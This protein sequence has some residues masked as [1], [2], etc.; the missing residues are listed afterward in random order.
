MSVIQAQ[1]SAKE[2]RYVRCDDEGRLTTNLEATIDDVLMKGE[3]A[4]GVKTPV[5]VQT[6]GKLESMCFGKTGAGVDKE[7]LV[8]SDGSFVVGGGSVKVG[9]TVGDGSGTG[10]FLKTASDGSVHVVVENS[11]N[12]LIKG[13][14]DGTTTQKDA[15]T[16]SNGD[17]RSALIGNTSKDGTGT[18]YY[19]LVDADGKLETSG[20]GGGGTQFAGGAALV[21]TGTGTAMIGRDSGNVARLVATDTS[22]HI[23]VVS[24]TGAGIALESAQTNGTQLARCMGNNSGSQVQIKVDANGV[25]ETSGGGG[26]GG[27][28]TTFTI[29]TK[30]VPD[31]TLTTIGDGTNAYID[32][33]GGSKFTISVLSSTFTGS[34]AMSIEWSDNASFSAGKV[35]VCN[36]YLGGSAVL[37][38]VMLM[39]ATR[40][41]GTTLAI[42]G[43]VAFENIP[44]R[45]ARITIEQTSGGAIV[46]VGNTVL[47]P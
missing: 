39:S 27:G 40:L 45:Y 5:L 12:V 42:Q 8:E 1:T 19:V 46:Y 14:Q 18:N 30:S 4:G 3:T 44:A 38:P 34:P 26:G 33:N 11:D 36:G 28:S 16:N 29:E 22:G 23:E 32:T 6:D 7:L 21:A 15:K 24:S 13:V 20:G 37:A 25:V 9:N 31:N 17:L 35:F 41:D 47:S 2:L 43:I 10:T